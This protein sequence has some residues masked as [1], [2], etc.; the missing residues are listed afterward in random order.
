MKKIQRYKIKNFLKTFKTPES[1]SQILD[2]S[3]DIWTEYPD[4]DEK[5]IYKLIEEQ[6]SISLK[7]LPLE[8]PPDHKNKIYTKKTSN[9]PEC[10]RKVKDVYQKYIDTSESNKSLLS[11]WILGTFVHNQFETY[12]LCNLNAQKR[13]GKSRT[14]KLSS[15]LAKNGDGSLTASLTETH[16]FRRKQGKP[17]FLDELES[18]NNKEQ[19]NLRELLNASYKRGTTITRYKEKRGE[20]QEETFAPFYPIM[21]ANI[22]GLNNVLADRS[23]EIILRRSNKEQTLLIEDFATNKDIIAL[24]NELNGMDITIPQD[25]FTEWN[26][27]IITGKTKDAALIGL[28]EKIKETELNGRYLEI[29]FPLIIISWLAEDLEDFLKIVKEYVTLRQEAELVDNFDERLK[30]FINSVELVEFVDLIELVELYKKTLETPESWINSNWMSKALKRLD[31]IAQKRLYNGRT[32]IRLKKELDDS[33]TKSTKSIISTNSTNS[34][35]NKDNIILSDFDDEG[36]T[37]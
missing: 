27:F 22:S 10:L 28:F 9:L 17:M 20:Y 2:I 24:K 16:L 33:S 7:D 35:N 4:I 6:F 11:H 36:V 1:K 19:G 14:L 34:T 15:C 21:I 37:P 13:A 30:L 5:E 32:Q 25:F 29:F 8:L 26:D 12:P 3:E 31:L 18:I 23:I